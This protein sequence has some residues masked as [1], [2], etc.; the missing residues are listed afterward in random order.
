MRR[1]E[2]VL[3]EVFIVNQEEMLL[4]KCVTKRIARRNKFKLQALM[5]QII[6][7]LD[8]TNRSR[9]KTLFSDRNNSMNDVTIREHGRHRPPLQFLPRS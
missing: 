9:R 1:K 7:A 4:T 5:R 3:R 2:E 6:T 8:V